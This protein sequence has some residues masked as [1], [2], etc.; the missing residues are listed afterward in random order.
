M[1]AVKLVEYEGDLFYLIT[2]AENTQN[3]MA[4]IH[5]FL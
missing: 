4:Y 5:Y 1:I 2:D 3:Q